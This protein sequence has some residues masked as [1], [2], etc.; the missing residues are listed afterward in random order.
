MSYED[1]KGKT[2]LITGASRGIGRAVAERLA[3]EGMRLALG[4]RS[5]KEAAEETKANCQA[6]GTE[7][8]L[9]DGDLGHKQTADNWVAQTLAR[10]GRLDVLVANAGVTTENPLALLDQNEIDDMLN[11]NIRGLVWIVQ[12]AQKPMLTARRGNIICLS[13]VLASRPGRGNAVY[14]GTKGFVES[15]TRAMAVEL[16][17]KN[18]RVNAVAPGVVATDMSQVVQELAGEQIKERIPL[19]RLATPQDIAGAVAYL[20]SQEAAYMT[21]SVLAIDGG[22]LGGW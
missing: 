7:V 21:G 6:L 2:A 16:G 9:C 22:F 4:Y 11:T 18:I 12:A 15:F 20:A 10:F 3:Q 5:N 8:I 13:S 17:R 19:K 14:A 1:L